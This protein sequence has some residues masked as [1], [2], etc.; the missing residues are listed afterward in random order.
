MRYAYDPTSGIPECNQFALHLT[1]ATGAFSPARAVL[2]H[3]GDDCHV[4]PLWVL[5]N[6]MLSHYD[7]QEKKG[8]K[9]CPNSFT[10]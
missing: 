4:I 10:V 5:V 3:I 8:Q 1:P 9:Y 6:Y 7:S 2:F